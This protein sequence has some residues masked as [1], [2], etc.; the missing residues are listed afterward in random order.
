MSPAKDPL[1]PPALPTVS[2]LQCPRSGQSPCWENRLCLAS[3]LFSVFLL[4]PGGGALAFHRDSMMTA[5]LALPF[6]W[7]LSPKVAFIV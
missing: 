7:L 1:Y 2:P 4:M 3:S 5:C 6:L